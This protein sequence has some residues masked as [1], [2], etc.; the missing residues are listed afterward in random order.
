[1][2]KLLTIILA[3]SLCLLVAAPAL[4]AAG[5][6]IFEDESKFQASGDGSDGVLIDSLGEGRAFYNVPFSDAWSVSCRVDLQGGNESAD[7][8]ANARFAIVDADYGLIGMVTAKTMIGRGAP[9]TRTNAQQLWNGNWSDIG[10]V[11]WT[12]HS[13]N[14]YDLTISKKSG[15][16]SLYVTLIDLDG[17]KFVDFKTDAFD[18]DAMAAAKYFA[19]Y[20]YGSKVL[21]SNISYSGFVSSSPNPGTGDYA[22]P[23]MIVAAIC[24]AG[25]IA[26]IGKKKASS[27]A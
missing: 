27:K 1:M 2:K 18:A 8:E 14:T 21:Y 9:D 19:F 5:D 24:S 20:V 25:V 16:N 15:D 23:L 4:A 22:L 6:Y 26:L 13:G 12:P 7:P 17:N 3:A 11:E 10:V